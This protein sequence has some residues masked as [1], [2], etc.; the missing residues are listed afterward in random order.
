MIVNII[1]V[2]AGGGIGSALRYGVHLLLGNAEATYP[3]ATILVNMVGSFLL[4]LLTGYASASTMNWNRDVLLFAGVGLCGGF[5]TFSTFSL[6]LAR[7]VE[8]EAYLPSAI[9]G[10]GSVMLGLLSVALGLWLG[11]YV[12]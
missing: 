9:Y 4:G 12:S 11:K 8:N 10:I 3:I 2:F 6:E 7:L 1:L 5:T